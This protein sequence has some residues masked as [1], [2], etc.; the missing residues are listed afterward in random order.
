ME[1]VLNVK[2]CINEVLATMANCEPSDGR[3][4]RKWRRHYDF[5]L[6]FKARYD[7]IRNQCHPRFN[8]ELSDNIREVIAINGLYNNSTDDLILLI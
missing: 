2:T 5:L 1:R 4:R 3:H 8:M 6:D 7:D